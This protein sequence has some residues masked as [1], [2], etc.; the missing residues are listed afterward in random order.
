MMLA[1]GTRAPSWAEN[2]I[3]T[4]QSALDVDT[5]ATLPFCFDTASRFQW[6]KMVAH[7]VHDAGFWGLLNLK[8]VAHP[9]AAN[10]SK[11]DEKT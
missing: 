2:L 9:P 10:T 1:P 6:C 8:C 3:E 11:K 5:C 7:D 4:I